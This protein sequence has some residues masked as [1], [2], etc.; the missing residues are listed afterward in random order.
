MVLGISKDKKLNYIYFLKKLKV[1]SII[2]QNGLEIGTTVGPTVINYL[3]CK[4]L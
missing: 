3:A 2:A 1:C 4:T